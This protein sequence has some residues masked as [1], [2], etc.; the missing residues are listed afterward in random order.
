[1]DRVYPDSR[2]LAR[3]TVIV[4]AVTGLHAVLGVGLLLGTAITLRPAPPPAIRLVDVKPDDVVA[5]KIPP[6][7]PVDFRPGDVTAPP[8]TDI[9]V[10]GPPSD[11]A[12]AGPAPASAPSARPAPSQPAPVV[13]AVQVTATGRQTLTDICGARYPAASRRL[14]EE[15][16][17]RLLVYVAPDGHAGEARVEASS[18][19][20]RLDAA[21]IACVQEAGRVFT[22][23]R[24]GPTPVGAWQSMSYRWVLGN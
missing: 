8:P 21:S 15:G 20:P 17:V 11:T 7:R 9:A 22:P 23:Q 6:P 2:P 12:I 24:T 4:G 18:G 16:A 13:T 14:N 3:R 5:P 19:F 10:I 1:M